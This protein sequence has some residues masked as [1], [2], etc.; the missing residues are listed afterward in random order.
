MNY[1][2][3]SSEE[4]DTRM[5]WDRTGQSLWIGGGATRVNLQLTDPQCQLIQDLLL[6]ECDWTEFRLNLKVCLRSSISVKGVEVKCVMIMFS[7]HVVFFLTG[8]PTDPMSLSHMMMSSL[9]DSKNIK[10]FPLETRQV[11]FV[12]KKNIDQVTL[13]NV[14]KSSVQESTQS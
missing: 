4:P 12:W 1:A 9:R 6:S 10:F 3:W 8:K 11:F 2:H 14:N 13:Y 5:L 7:C